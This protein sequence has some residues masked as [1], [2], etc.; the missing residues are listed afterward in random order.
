MA[1]QKAFKCYLFGSHFYLSASG[2]LSLIST[3]CL[4][5]SVR[6]G[7]QI[8]TILSVTFISSCFRSLFPGSH[9]S[10]FPTFTFFILEGHILQS[11]RKLISE[12]SHDWKTC[13]FYLHRW[14]VV[15]LGFQFYTA[16][17]FCPRILKPLVCP[18]CPCW[19]VRS[20]S[21]SQWPFFFPLGSSGV[22]ESSF[23][24][25]WCSEIS[26]IYCYSCFLKNRY[27]RNSRGVFEFENH[28]P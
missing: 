13:L 28:C 15:C 3:H 21:V 5:H 9:H 27:I 10:L 4:L 24:F 14:P 19:D 17:Y 1:F 18:Q 2:H 26:R 12:A 7:I 6:C 16:N 11:V 22:W 23:F 8:N 20:H 25:P